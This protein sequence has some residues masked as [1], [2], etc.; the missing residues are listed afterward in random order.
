MFFGAV[1]PDHLREVMMCVHDLGLVVHWK[2][3]GVL[4]QLSYPK[5]EII[6]YNHPNRVENCLIAMLQQWLVSGRATKQ[7]LVDVLQRFR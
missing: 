7:A 6:E 4:L 1:G 5:L 2:R 3:I